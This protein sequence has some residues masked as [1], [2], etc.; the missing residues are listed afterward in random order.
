MRHRDPIA[1]RWR[2][3]NSAGIAIVGGETANALRYEARTCC[4]AVEAEPSRRAF[5]SHDLINIRGLRNVPGHRQATGQPVATQ[6][7]PPPSTSPGQHQ[8]DEKSPTRESR[9]SE[10]RLDRQVHRHLGVALVPE[11]S[12]EYPEFC[13]TA[14]RQA[15]WERSRAA[16]SD[17]G[18]AS[19]KCSAY[20]PSGEIRYVIAVCGTI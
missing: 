1:R 4:E 18:N 13:R 10:P 8:Q 12:L 9:A 16:S 11:V 6:P 20:S 3:I 2:L 5:V 14:D 15:R 19:L 7:L 17:S